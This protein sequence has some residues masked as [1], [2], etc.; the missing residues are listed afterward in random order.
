MS[1][2]RD[3]TTKTFKRSELRSCILK[4][5]LHAVCETFF[6]HELKI[7]AFLFTFKAKKDFE[8]NTQS[9]FVMRSRFSF[10]IVLRHYNIL[11]GRTI[12]TSRLG[13]L[14][15]PFLIIW[16]PSN[17]LYLSKDTLIGIWNW[18]CCNHSCILRLIILHLSHSFFN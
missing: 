16:A 18:N 5:E 12:T 17:L 10:F 3:D 6:R 15:F 11:P 1:S 9:L 8:K 2:K 4:P 14:V 13:P 7:L